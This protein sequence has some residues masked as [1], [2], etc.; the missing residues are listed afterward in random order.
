M[1]FLNVVTVAIVGALALAIALFVQR[2][3]DGIDLSP[4]ALLRVYLYIASLAGIAVLASGLAA[5][6]AFS[7]AQPL[8]TDAVYGSSGAFASVPCPAGG[9]DCKPGPSADDVRRMNDERDRRVTEDL[10]RGIT[11]T[12]LGALFFGA[13]R[14][15]RKAVN[16]DEPQS[17]L[18]RGYLMI[19]TV[20]FGLAAITMLPSG[21]TTVITNKVAGTSTEFYR[22]AAGQELGAGLVALVV[23]LL[24]LWLV[25]RDFRTAR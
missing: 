9:V 6:V 4:R 12:A 10:V 1:L 21:L 17:L 24:Y 11:F 13:H 8:G 5:L 16:S 2:G 18:L 19:G 15:A 25:V 22:Q 20:A 14:A 3:R 23:W 7:L